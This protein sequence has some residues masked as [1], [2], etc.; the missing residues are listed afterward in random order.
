MANCTNLLHLKCADGKVKDG[1]NIGV[2][3]GGLGCRETQDF[4]LGV[5][6]GRGVSL[7]YYDIL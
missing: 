6:W 1:D 7:K 2:N 5:S 3:L 4:G